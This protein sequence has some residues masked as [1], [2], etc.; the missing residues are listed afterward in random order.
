MIGGR[1]AGRPQIG[2]KD[3]VVRRVGKQ[4]RLHRDHRVGKKLDAIFCRRARE[5]DALAPAHPEALEGPRRSERLQL[6]GAHPGAPRQVAKVGIIATPL[7]LGHD[8]LGHPHPDALDPG[9]A[10][11]HGEGAVAAVGGGV[12]GRADVEL[13]DRCLQAVGTGIHARDLCRRRERR[14]AAPRR[15]CGRRLGRGQRLHARVHPR[16]VQVGAQHP[17]PVA[18]SIGG[19]R[20]R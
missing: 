5:P 20:C 3:L 6:D 15:L 18:P 19:E 1:D 12:V 9:K 11:P 17:H 16:R 13:T 14:P 7:P 4:R 8:L 2:G 10:E